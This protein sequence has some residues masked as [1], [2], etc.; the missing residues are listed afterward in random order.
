MNLAYGV[1]FPP[2]QFWF[3][4]IIT[5]IQLGAVLFSSLLIVSMTFDRFY[6]IIMPH[7]AA[8]F[9]TVKRAKITIV[10]ILIFSIITNIPHLFTTALE[11][12][13]SVPFDKVMDQP[14]G[15]LFYWFSFVVSFIF[16]FVFNV[17]C[18]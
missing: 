11:G 10:N 14:W 9:N 13:Q 2:S 17:C 8:S 15:Q 18:F 6:S 4:A 7:K 3:A 16:P 1:N 5:T 12:R